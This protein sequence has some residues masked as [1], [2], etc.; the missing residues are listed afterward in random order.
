MIE[1]IL[2]CLPLKIS[3]LAAALTQQNLKLSNLLLAL[4]LI[5][6]QRT[7][8][9]GLS[10]F[11]AEIVGITYG[12]GYYTEGYQIYIGSAIITAYFAKIQ[13]YK[14]RSSSTAFWCL[15]LIS[16][17][18]MAAYDA[19]YF[20]QTETYFYN[21]YPSI[22]LFIHVCLILSFYKTGAVFIGLV[23]KFRAVR[24]VLSSNY[25]YQ[26]FCYTARYRF[27]HRAN[28]WNRQT[29]S[30]LFCKYIKIR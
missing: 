5:T 29:Q 27:K 7:Y 24:G 25:T 12:F 21:A 1:G 11:I 3:E 14:T 15:A 16:F 17:Y 8:L 19:K 20:P 9:L 22:L 13:L 6:H 4:Y 30:R 10:F 26:Y 28:Q 2:E 23:D 18:G